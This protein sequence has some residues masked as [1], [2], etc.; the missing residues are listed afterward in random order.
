MTTYSTKTEA[1]IEEEKL[2][3]AKLLSRTIGWPSFIISL[4]VIILQAHLIVVT[5]A[6][7]FPLLT[8]AALKVKNLVYPADKKN[9]PVSSIVSGFLWPVIT[10]GVVLDNY[11]S[12]LDFN[13]LWLLSFILFL[14]LALI[15]LIGNNPLS[16]NTGKKATGAM[17]MLVFI[18]L[19]CFIASLTVNC[20]YDKAPPA[21]YAVKVIDKYFT[22]GR[23]SNYYLMLAQ[24]NTANTGRKGKVSSSLYYRTQIGDYV[25]VGRRSGILGA[26]W[27]S[28]YHQ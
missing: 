19:Y 6:L 13:I 22:H 28:V 26:P 27:Y 7:L 4:L 5:L 2:K 24:W 18:Y 1:E 21:E 9:R 15:L 14:I 11:V 10:L 3:K 16:L 8:I 25:T 23:N 17:L 12:V 20:L